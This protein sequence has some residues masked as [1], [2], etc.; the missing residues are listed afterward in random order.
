EDF[1]RI[2]LRVRVPKLDK[3]ELGLQLT[4]HN[5]PE[6]IVG[7]TYQKNRGR[8]ALAAGSSR[9]SL[10]GS[11]LENRPTFTLKDNAYVA[12]WSQVYAK[13]VLTQLVDLTIY[14]KSEDTQSFSQDLLAMKIEYPEDEREIAE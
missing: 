9:G 10:P 11:E 5:T 3:I 2:Y 4:P 13:D 6:T 7:W 14:F 1:V 12:E 8:E